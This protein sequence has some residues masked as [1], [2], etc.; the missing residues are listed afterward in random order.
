MSRPVGL[1]AV[2]RGRAPS[3]SAT[4]SV[5][6][7][8]LVTVAAVAA[9]VNAFADRYATWR[10]RDRAPDGAPE[11]PEGPRL[12]PEADGALMAWPSPPAVLFLDREEARAAVEAGARIVAGQPA[13]AGALSAP[14]EAHVAVT[15]R[16]PVRCDA[17]Y[18]DAGPDRA[19]PDPSTDVL[20]AQLDAL[21][22][23]GVLEIA[24][25]G[26]EAGVRDDLPRLAAA[27]RDRGMVPNLT[28]SGIGL[29]AARAAALAGGF[30]QVNV[31]LD[32][33]GA[34][35][36]RVR[37]WQG[38]EVALTAIRHLVASG[39]RVGV[40]TVLTRDNLD[41]LP[42]MA[43]ALVALGVSEWQWIRLKP[44]GRGAAVYAERALTPEQALTLWPMAL[45]AERAGLVMRFDCAL[46][47]FLAAHGVPPEHL[48]RLG[49]AG[50][51]AGHSLL[52]RMADGRWAP[53]SFAHASASESEDFSRTWSSDPTLVAWRERA[54]SPPEPCG[55]CPWRA[56]CRG[57]CRVVS[58]HLTGDALAPDPECPRV[59]AA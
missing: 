9:V 59:R 17:C 3:C 31:S 32:G 38:A 22:A 52:A 18:L 34:T 55:S 8:A 19:P 15:G 37:G 45:E 13:P 58:A 57:G 26:G 53:C 2:R 28:T 5:V 33:L 23:A 36:R 41:D 11:P 20:E 49:V 24:F 30:A 54:V 21:A 42:A 16:C 4:G 35:Y 56:V 46:V 27:V 10:D 50:C 7:L 39:T 44:A 25:G 47:P 48:E 51:P 40:N 6:G 29:D 14:I 43:E 1:R 12:R